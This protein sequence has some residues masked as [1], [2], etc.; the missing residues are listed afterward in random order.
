MDT[1]VAANPAVAPDCTAS[2]TVGACTLVRIQDGSMPIEAGCTGNPTTDA[3][4]A[5][6]LTAAEQAT[7]QQWIADGQV[8]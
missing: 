8:Q 3:G 2:E 6:C 7:L 1:Q 4:N 5:A